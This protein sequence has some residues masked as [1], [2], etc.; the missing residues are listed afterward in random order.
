MS[1]IFRPPF[2]LPTP[3]QSPLGTLSLA[4]TGGTIQPALF[5]NANQF[6][7]PTIRVTL[8]P[9]ALANASQYFAPVIRATLKPAALANANT[10]FVPSV[11]V[12]AANIQPG[13]FTNG[14]SFFA[15]VLRLAVR[16]AALSNA[17]AFFS[18]R[19]NLA[20]R[21]AAHANAPVFF[22]PRLSLRISPAAYANAQA[23][24]AA[25]I[26]LPGI[27]AAPFLASAGTIF[28]PSVNVAFAQQ[29][30]GTL[31]VAGWT[32]EGPRR[33]R[34]KAPLDWPNLPKVGSAPPWRLT[35]VTPQVAREQARVRLHWRKRAEQLRRRRDVDRR[36][37]GIVEDL[38]DQEVA[39]TIAQL[40]AEEA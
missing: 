27:K 39:R 7:A 14:Q 10:F 29:V 36:V 37:A 33:A 12:G 40:I 23:F 21:P 28:A 22:G 8:K 11:A 20:L 34:R 2:R 13:L 17:Q 38:V 25:A 9:A 19:S 26:V 16:P 1:G 24:G 15:T 35:V 3:V 30:V 6:F 5:A 4:A 18:A 31:N 32:R